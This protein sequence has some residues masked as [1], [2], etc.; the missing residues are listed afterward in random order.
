[1]NVILFSSDNNDQ[2]IQTSMQ[3]TLNDNS[4]WKWSDP[5]ATE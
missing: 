3:V 2:L 1:M 5:E 4:V